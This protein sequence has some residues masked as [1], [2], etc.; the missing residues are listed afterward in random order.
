MAYGK[1]YHTTTYNKGLG[2]L[3]VDIYKKD[4]VGAISPLTIAFEG[5]KISVDTVEYFEMIASTSVDIDVINDKTDFYELDALFSTSDLEHYILIYNDDVVLFRGFIP[6]D[7]VEQSWL[8]NGIVTISAT[9]NLNRLEEYIPTIFEVKGTYTLMEIIQHCLTFTNMEISGAELPIYVNCSLRELTKPNGIN[10]CFDQTWADTDIFYEDSTTIRDCKTVMEYILGAFDCIIYYYNDAWY[11]ERWKDLAGYLETKNYI[12]YEGST[13]SLVPEDIPAS[14]YP[15]VGKDLDM[16]CIEQSQRISYSPGFKTVEV[17]LS[18]TLRLNLVD[19]YYSD[20][21]SNQTMATLE[22]VNPS[23]GYWE[24]I[25]E[26]DITEYSGYNLD[27]MS[28]YIHMAD[29]W[30]SPD[31]EFDNGFW[32]FE[33]VTSETL[34]RSTAGMFA[35]FKIKMN[36]EDSTNPTEEVS[37]T[38]NISFTFKLPDNFT[39]YGTFNYYY[40]TEPSKLNFWVRLF[41]KYNDNGTIKW[42]KYN[43]TNEQYEFVTQSNIGSAGY[44]MP[45]ILKE[46]NFDTFTNKTAFYHEFTTTINLGTAIKNVTGDTPEFTLGLM[47]LGYTDP[48]LNHNDDVPN[49]CLHDFIYGDIYV[50]ANTE[51]DDNVITGTINEDFVT[52][53][54]ATMNLYDSNNFSISNGLYINE[55]RDHTTSWDDNF[56]RATFLPLSKHYIQDRFQIYHTVRRHIITDAQS[57]LYL[58]PFTMVDGNLLNKTFCVNGFKYIVDSDRYESLQLSEYVND[59]N[60]S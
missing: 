30:E 6:C 42:V 27:T 17:T 59:D 49:I 26:S 9:V 7:V 13:V 3:N 5:I 19:Y 38:L 29:S 54:D 15:V 34:R 50:T 18:E 14:L 48:D 20:I 57:L 21:Q 8:H 56:L 31:G 22:Q 32:I 43:E 25:A 58:K 55:D 36:E 16:T 28:N 39:P 35:K 44:G 60:I 10:T 53:E 37:T 24:M 40:K 47:K 4:Y 45:I 2:Q 1:K 41:L 23:F 52:V 46:V 12:K 11:I 51:V 33:G